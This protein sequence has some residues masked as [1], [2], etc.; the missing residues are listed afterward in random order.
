MRGSSRQEPQQESLIASDP[1]IAEAFRE[2]TSSVVLNIL[3]VTTPGTSC[4]PFLGDLA[5][6]GHRVVIAR[7]NEQALEN[8]YDEPFDLVLCHRSS[9]RNSC[10]EFAA[11]L[12]ALDPRQQILVLDLGRALSSEYVTKTFSS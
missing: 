12:R 6:L 5:A 3:L 2:L 10:E 8:F 7:S 9:E 1:E 11:Y 4:D